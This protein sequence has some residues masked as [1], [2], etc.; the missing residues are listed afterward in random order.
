MKDSTPQPDPAP[1]RR[2]ALA[3]AIGIAAIVLA[4]VIIAILA[5]HR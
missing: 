2:G 1:P 5:R 4:A 3:A